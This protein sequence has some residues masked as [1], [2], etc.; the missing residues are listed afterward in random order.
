MCHK[1]LERNSELA[2]QWFEENSMNLNTDKCRLL[3]SGHKYEYQQAQISKDQVWEEYKVKL[4]G[5]AIDNKLIFDS[6]FWNIYS[7]TKKKKCFMKTLSQNL[8][9]FKLK[10]AHS[11]YIT[12]IFRHWKQKC[13]KFIRGFH[14]SLFWI[15][16]ILKMKITFIFYN[17]SQTFKFQELTLL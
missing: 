12:K 5:I 10:M 3:I 13:L 4:L 6:H 14:K 9:V 16:L 17:L 8:K 7:K 11:L 15:C 2:T 1:N